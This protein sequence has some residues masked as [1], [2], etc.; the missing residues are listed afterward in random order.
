MRNKTID[1]AKGIAIMM[2]VLGHACQLVGGGG[3]DFTFLNS[4]DIDA[5][6]HVFEWVLCIV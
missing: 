5:I 4:N 1:F 2:V 3:K 6:L